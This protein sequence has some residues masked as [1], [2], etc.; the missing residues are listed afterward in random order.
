MTKKP[1]RLSMISESKGEPMSVYLSIDLGTTGCRSVLFDDTLCQLA[2]SYEE[3]GLITPKEDEVEQDAE[4]W[5]EITLR[6]AKS[7][8]EKQVLTAKQS[9]LFR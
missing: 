9:N 4:L 1:E 6:T 8:I 5:W 7:A 2:I 3:Y